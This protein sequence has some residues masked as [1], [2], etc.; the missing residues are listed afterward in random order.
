MFSQRN[1]PYCDLLSVTKILKTLAHKKINMKK[2]LGL[3]LG[4]N[5]IGWALIEID[6]NHEPIRIIAMGSRI[7]PLDSKERDQFQQGQAISKNQDRT[8]A[9]TQRKGYD[10]KQLKKNDDFKYSLKKTLELH[11]IYPSKELFN[12]PMLDLWKLRSEAALKPIEP[13]Q[14]GRI[15]YM[16]NQKR[17][18]KSAKNEANADKKDTEYVQT[19]KGRY[20]QLKDCNQTIGQF[21]FEKLS[22]AYKDKDDR[23]Y[24]RIKDEVYPR[25]AYI[26]EFD[27]IISAQKGHHS[28]LTDELIH[29]LR[30]EI[31]YYQRKLKSQK[32]LLSVCEFEG[33][34]KIIKDKLG[35][36]KTVVVGPK[37]A[38]RS[39][40][41]FQLCR[42]WETVNNINIKVKN[43]PGA[44]YKWSD[45]IPTLDEK[46]QLAEH[47]WKGEQLSF[48]DLLRI[49]DLKKDEVYS[50][51]QILKGIKGNLIKFLTI[52]HY[53][54]LT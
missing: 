49:L 17:G 8:T 44:K 16:L 29:S 41:L 18:Y 38:A 39:N 12:L 24:F 2:I 23:T 34:E 48:M 5:S 35:N 27:A 32:G 11:G 43:V 9:R 25:E 1:N 53:L 28:F 51:K 45:R 13:E 26:E 50:N 3:D 22:D 31:I 4:T 52:I 54:N 6:E 33:F 15:L 37:V 46:R 20:A 47:L 21:F 36:Q 14:F 10:R 19:V 30:D 40:P 42:I 7:I